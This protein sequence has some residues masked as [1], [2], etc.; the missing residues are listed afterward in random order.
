MGASLLQQQAGGRA[1][2][3][4]LRFLE[5]FAAAPE[6]R[7]ALHAVVL[8]GDSSLL[9]AR[10]VPRSRLPGDDKWAT[11][12]LVQ[13]P[14]ERDPRLSNVCS[15]AFCFHHVQTLF[16]E[17]LGRTTAALAGE[18]HEELLAVLLEVAPTALWPGADGAA[19]A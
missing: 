14:L 19:A 18:G 11:S 15:S 8:D 9:Q 1:G 5:S 17:A 6:E 12:L 2:P 16:R 10:H 4:L 3:M 13:D 7:D